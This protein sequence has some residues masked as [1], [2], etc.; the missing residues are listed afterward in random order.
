MVRL[1]MK[2]YVH[3]PHC[4]SR[5]RPCTCDPQEFSSATEA[6]AAAR[7]DSARMEVGEITPPL[8]PTWWPVR[9]QAARHRPLSD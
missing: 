9:S 2:L 3:K 7:G 4:A 8:R 5:R 6:I 1:P